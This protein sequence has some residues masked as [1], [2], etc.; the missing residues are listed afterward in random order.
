MNK[1]VL[2][3]LFLWQGLPVETVAECLADLTAP[4]VFEKGAVI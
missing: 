3:Q 1:S 2:E 4:A